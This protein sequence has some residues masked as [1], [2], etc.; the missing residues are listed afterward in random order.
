MKIGLYFGSFNP[1][2][3]GHLLIANH[4]LNARLIEKLWFVLSPRNPFK[5]TKSLLD[6]YDRLHLLKIAVES[7]DRMRVTDV[8]FSLPRPSYTSVTL[9]H[10]S[11][12]YPEHQFYLII[13]G[14]SLQ[15]FHSW[16]NASFIA[17][18]FPLL[19]YPRPGSDISQAVARTYEDQGKKVAAQIQ[20][21]D[22][23]QFELS[24]T[25][26]RKHIS[27]GQSIRYMVPERVR[28]E[29]LQNGYYR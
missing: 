2:H 6:E 4:F 20:V 13:G 18:N 25:D 7:D 10:L 28:E 21:V 16:K 1:I 17:A 11:E 22:A 29:I 14:D 23:P 26:I 15:N 3:T 8:E 9:M 12:K 24:S 27:A 5:E 19:V